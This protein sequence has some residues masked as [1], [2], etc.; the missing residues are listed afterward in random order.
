MKLALLL[1]VLVV[2]ALSAAPQTQPKPEDLAKDSAD[3][4]L[5]LVD[6]GKYADSY[7]DAAESFKQRV[8]KGQWES[9]AKAVRAPLGGLQSRKLKSITYKTSLPG[10]PD[11]QY[12]ILQYDS[13]FDHKQ[14]AVETVTPLLDKDGT[15]RVSGYFIK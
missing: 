13:S 4:W 11:G 2:P 10:A 1:F 9:T 8:S 7:R 15:W 14:S 6:A 12:V 5:A 3:A